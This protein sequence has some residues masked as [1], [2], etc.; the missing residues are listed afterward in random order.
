MPKRPM[1]FP[2]QNFA[3]TQ[4]SATP[5]TPGGGATQQLQNNQ[6]MTHT[7]KMTTND[8][9]IVTCIKSFICH[10]TINFT[11]KLHYMVTWRVSLG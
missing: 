9:Y 5:G 1:G 7:G 6:G 8:I 10:Y 11:A 2:T 3:Q 4:V